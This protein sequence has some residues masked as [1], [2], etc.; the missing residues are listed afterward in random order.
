[1]PLFIQPTITNSYFIVDPTPN[2]RSL[3]VLLLQNTLLVLALS[4]KTLTHY[5]PPLIIP[6][7]LLPNSPTCS[8]IK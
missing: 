5:Y 7:S 4:S 2:I 6:I 3:L 8:N 1:M